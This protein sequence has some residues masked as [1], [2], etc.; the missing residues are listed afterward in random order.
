[1]SFIFRHIFIAFLLLFSKLGNAQP[2]QAPFEKLIV[3]GLHDSLSF[4]F[5]Q[6]HRLFSERWDT[7]SQPKF[8]RYVMKL[9]PDSGVLNIAST[10][11]I[12]A[13]Y[14]TKQWYAMPDSVKSRI[15]DSIRNELCLNPDEKIYFTEGK[16]HYYDYKNAI[17]TISRGIEIFEQNN[18][19]PFYAQVILLIESPG[20]SAR[21]NV[22]ALGPF[23]L[24][25]GVAKN[26]GLRVDKELDERKDFDRSAYAAA[27]L[28][29]TV[30]IPYADSI[31]KKYGI[32]YNPTDIWFRLLVLHVYHAGALN[33]AKAVDVIQPCEGSPDLI[34][35]LWKTK[36]GAFG[37]ASQNYTQIA[38]AS[39]FE[40]HDIIYNNCTNLIIDAV[41]SS[42]MLNSEGLESSN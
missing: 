4:N 32:D 16:G 27:K 35:Q 12:I 11:Q 34:H 7:L 37:N 26:M 18:T 6:D 38:L 28:I 19:D 5:V 8:W 1:M 39:L 17:P 30:C 25:K 41:N 20:K 36:A 29:R 15:R 33:V 24:M 14:A 40:L 42:A 10:R 21:S 2:M 31:V 9:T 13:T 3:S 23:Q 22:G